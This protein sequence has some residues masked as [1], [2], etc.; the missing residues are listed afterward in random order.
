MLRGLLRL[1]FEMSP[2]IHILSAWSTADSD[3]FEDC[4][5]LGGGA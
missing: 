1:K 3:S 5:T 4:G 2:Q